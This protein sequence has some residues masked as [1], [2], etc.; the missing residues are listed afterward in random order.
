MATTFLP[1]PR[2][3]YKVHTDE[4]SPLAL[5]ASSEPTKTVP[6][7][8]QRQGF[9]PRVLGDFGDGGAFP[10]I[11]AAQFPL[12]MGRPATKKSGTGSAAGGAGGGGGGIAGISGLGNNAGST[13]IV[14]VDVD[15]TGK[16]RPD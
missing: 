12:D 6:P 3:N 1:A 16:V 8:G 14:A 10:E 4:P 7:Y 15:E 2:H 5:L 11:H 13:A 9:V